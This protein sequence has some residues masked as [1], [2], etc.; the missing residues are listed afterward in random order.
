[1]DFLELLLFVLVLYWL[2]GHR[3]SRPASRKPIPQRTH[4]AELQ[5][6]LRT[7]RDILRP[8]PVTPAPQTRPSTY[9]SQVEEFHSLEQVELGRRVLIA[10]V[11][12][13]PTPEPA[14]KRSTPLPSRW[15]QR[16]MQPQALQEAFVMAELLGAPRA[17][18]PWRPRMG[19]EHVRFG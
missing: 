8:E 14:Q 5:E 12:L 4:D 18:R 11:Q 9:P 10:P 3:R 1:M 13:G 2:L 6:A 17:R 19:L 16:L 7:I 15:G